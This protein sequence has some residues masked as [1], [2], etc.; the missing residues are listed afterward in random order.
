MDIAK[1]VR[2][3]EPEPDDDFVTKRTEAIKALKIWLLKRRNNLELTALGSGICQVFR[4]SPSMPD[5]IANQVEDA[6]KKQ[7]ASFVRDDSEL[8]MGVCAAAAGLQAI[9]CGSKAQDRLSVADVLAVV[10][11]SSLSFLPACK[12][13]KLE[14]FRVLAVDAARERCLNAG[15]ETRKRHDVPAFG[16]FGGE[17]TDTDNEPF[18]SATAPTVDALRLNA[19]LDREEIDLL[20][21]VLGGVSESFRRP[22]QALSPEVRAVTTG[23]EIGALMRA[24]PTQSHRNLVLRGIEEADPLSLPKLLEALGED[25]LV[26]ADSVKNESLIDRAP[27]VFPLLAAVRS[28]KGTGRSSDVPRLLP[29]WGARA[30]FERGVLRVLQGNYRGI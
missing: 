21:W 2:I 6:I 8:E 9:E 25:R 4:D 5:A 29:E 11:W 17:E 28:G 16:A 1:S 22:L 7:S 15:L 27:L 3:F 30:L 20:W 13:P 10:L 24:L 12:A 18:A 23:I 19:A 14:E 26:I